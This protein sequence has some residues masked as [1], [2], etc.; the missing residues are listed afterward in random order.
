MTNMAKKKSNKY[1]KDKVLQKN[2][3]F[4]T[5]FLTCLTV[6][7]TKGCDLLFP[8]R[9]SIKEVPIE[10]MVIEHSFDFGDA[11][12]DS[13]VNMRIDNLIKL[14]QIESK[15]NS[16][17]EEI[18]TNQVL[19]DNVCPNAK[20]YTLGNSSPYCTIDLIHTKTGFIDSKLKFLDITILNQIS[21]VGVK[22]FREK[23]DGSKVFVM[24]INYLPKI[25]N[26]MRIANTLTT[27]SYLFEI[28]FTFKKDVNDKYPTFYQQK[29]YLSII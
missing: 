18:V 4:K 26:T 16:K 13:L 6:A 20:G 9:I 22:V 25:D 24:D 3:F 10:H 14:E 12:D 27:G 19:L 21:F 11:S 23:D 7:L 29:K 2:G 28:G 8:S 1:K 5:I 15:L 17:V